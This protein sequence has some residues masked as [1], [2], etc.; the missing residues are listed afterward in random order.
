MQHAQRIVVI[1]E[2]PAS[3][4]AAERLIAAGMC[5]DVVS[6]RPAPFGLL[7]RFAGLAG[8]R[9]ESIASGDCGPDAEPRLRLIGNVRVGSGPDADI[10][11]RELHQ[12]AASEDRQLVLLELAVRGVPVTTWE[13]LCAPLADAALTDWSAVAERAQRAPVCF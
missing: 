8:A 11:H 6:E 1:G 3:L 5:V 12:L 7:R 4:S 13:G 2:G 10:S 9:D